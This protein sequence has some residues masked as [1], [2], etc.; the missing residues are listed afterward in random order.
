MTNM[1]YKPILSIATNENDRSHYREA[2]SAF[3]WTN[4]GR[5]SY[6]NLQVRLHDTECITPFDFFF[7]PAKCIKTKKFDIKL[8]LFSSLVTTISLSGTILNRNSFFDLL[9][10]S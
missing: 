2:F 6:G 8:H 5:I 7:G 4:S 3:D 9:F 1:P 10:E